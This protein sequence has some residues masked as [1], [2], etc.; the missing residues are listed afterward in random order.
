[1]DT[2]SCRMVTN[3]K[4]H[5]C[6]GCTRTMP[7]GTE[8]QVV[9]TVDSREFAEARWCLVCQAVLD[10]GTYEYD[11]QFG[12]GDM[13]NDPDWEAT[14]ESVEGEASPVAAS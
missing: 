2:L 12:F 9:V 3:R 1:M 14:R 5:K 11:D 10:N 6:W 8:M 4:P 13:R 7:P